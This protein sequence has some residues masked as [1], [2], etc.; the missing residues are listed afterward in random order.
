[1]NQSGTYGAQICTLGKICLTSD[2][3]PYCTE[4]S[5]TNVGRELVTG[6]VFL[7]LY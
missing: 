2:A 7:I 6:I 3:L 4:I 5:T 1:M